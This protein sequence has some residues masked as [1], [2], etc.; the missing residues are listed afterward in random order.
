VKFK[1]G[2]DILMPIKCLQSK[3]PLTS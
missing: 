2:T 3:I 1:D